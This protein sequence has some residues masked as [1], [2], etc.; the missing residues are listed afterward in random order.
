MNKVQGDILS[1]LSKAELL[2]VIDMQQRNWW[3]LQNNWMAYMNAEYGVDAAVK[4]DTHCFA[5]NARVQVFRLKRLLGLGE[6]VDALMQAMVLSTIWANGEYD[7]WK[8]DQRTLRI[9]VTACHQQE[10]RLEDGVGELPCKPAGTAIAEAAA[11]AVNPA[12]RVRCIVCPPDA[13]PERVWCE[14]EFDLPHAEAAAA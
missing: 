12:C 4:G 6:D 2:D 14:W 7:V 9:R 11:Q 1:K 8:V 13:R 10:R 5:A 3:N